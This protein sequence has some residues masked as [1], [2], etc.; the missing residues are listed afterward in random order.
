MLHLKS[1]TIF[2]I[3]CKTKMCIKNSERKY[4]LEE[5]GADRHPWKSFF[6]HNSGISC[7]A[8]C[9]PE[10]SL[11]RVSK[12]HNPTAALHP[13]MASVHSVIRFHVVLSL[14]SLS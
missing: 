9:H 6:F 14:L 1:K 5:A 13:P 7:I 2:D 8:E 10:L 4:K 12:R 11:V 3:Y